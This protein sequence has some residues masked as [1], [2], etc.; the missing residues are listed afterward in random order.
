MKQIQ[1]TQGK[2]ALV[3][4]NDFDWLNQWKWC[5]A[6]NG[7]LWRAI[8]TKYDNNIKTTVFMH[9][10]IMG[11]CGD[12]GQEVDHRNRNG[13][14]NRRDN[15]RVCNHS[16]NVCNRKVQKHTSIYKG[17]YWNTSRKGWQAL[18]RSNLKSHYLGVFNS[19]VLAAKAYDEA[20]QKYHGEFAALNFPIS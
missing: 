2:F 18:I 13:L 5:A 11:L 17:V 4:D 7:G 19:E 12:G 15:L 14:D 20:A 6:F 3:D 16:E 8:R 10:E 9:R 1:L